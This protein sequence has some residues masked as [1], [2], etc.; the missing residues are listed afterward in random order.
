ME[1]ALLFS[2]IVHITRNF[3]V[4]PKAPRQSYTNRVPAN[5]NNRCSVEISH[6]LQTFGLSINFCPSFPVPHLHYPPLADIFINAHNCLV[7]LGGFLLRW[8]HLYR[9]R[10]GKY[11]SHKTQ[12]HLNFIRVC[13]YSSQSPESQSKVWLRNAAKSSFIDIGWAGE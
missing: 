12:L 9:P 10:I 7:V 3:C 1:P 5:W 4:L 11:I 6:S 13:F 8:N 2:L